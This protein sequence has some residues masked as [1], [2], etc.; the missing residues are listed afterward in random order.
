M[1]RLKILPLGGLGEIGMNCLLLEYDGEIVLLDCGIQFP[2][3]RFPGVD[4]L[5]PDLTYVRERKKQVRGVVITHGHDDHIGAIPFLAKHMELDVHCTPFPRGLIEQKISEY[6]DLKEIRLHEIR[7]REKFKAGPFRFD[8]IPVQHSII[9]SLGFAIETPIGTVVHTGDFKHD[10]SEAGGPVKDFAEF[11]EWGDKGVQ[12]LL[13][14][15][16]N[17]ERQGHTISEEEVV[18]SFQSI[19][20]KQKGRLLV[21]LFASNIRRIENLLWLAK[22]MNKR[23]A[24]EGRSMHSYVHIAHTQGSMKVPDDTIVLIENIHEYPDESVIVLLTGSQAEPQSALVRIASG[25]HKSFKIKQTDRVLLSSRFIPGNERAITAMIDHLYRQGAEVTY[26]SIH[27]IHVSGHGFQEE[28]A[29]ML[30]ATRPKFFVPI[31][32]EFRHLAMHAKLAKANGVAEANVCVVEDG[33][34]VEIGKDSIQLGEKLELQKGIIVSGSYMDGDP[35]LFTQRAALAKTGIV[36][37]SLLRRADNPRKLSHKPRVAAYGL[38]LGPGEQ[39]QDVI[40][41]AEDYIEDRY[42]ELAKEPDLTES[43]RIE[44]RRFFKKHSALKPAVISVFLDI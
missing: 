24:F 7:P 44:L 41:Q 2:D 1:K 38:L 37:V 35:A 29:M 21:A 30:R 33:Q 14:D 13:S 32:G 12:L 15:S 36:F 27:Q 39:L 26:E 10:A 34:S 28:L 5:T 25:S 4:L 23:V 20:A 18:N 17:A 3:A 16:T 6:S 8:P 31:H 9:E 40:E 19:F 11:H 22:K 42:P 43:L